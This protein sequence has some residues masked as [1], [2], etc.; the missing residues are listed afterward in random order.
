MILIIDEATSSIDT[1]TEQIIQK[2]LGKLMLGRTSLII[3]HR[4]RS[5]RS[6]DKIMVLE[7]GEIMNG[8]HMKNC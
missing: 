5:V 4:L 1:R 7:N 6:A 8:A 3:A 2:G